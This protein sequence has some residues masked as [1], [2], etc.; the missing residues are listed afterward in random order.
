M[1]ADRYGNELSTSSAKARDS[2]VAATDALL[3]ADH[4][5]IDGF[6]AAIAEDPDFKLA[7]A[8]LARA[9]QIAA[10]GAGAKAAMAAAEAASGDLTAREAG[11]MAA[12][13]QLIDG[14]MASYP[15]LRAHLA[16]HP[17]DVLIAQPSVGVF[18]LIGFS[19]LPGREAELLAYTAS[20]APH[21]G[22]D[23]WMLAQHGF[24][25]CEAGQVEKAIPLLD[26][27][28]ELYGRNANAAHIRA[29][30]Y[31]EAGEPETGRA[32]LEDW[33]PGYDK[34]G[35][36]HSHISWHIALWAM[37]AGDLDAMW[38]RVDA[39]VGPG[40]SQGLSINILTDTVALLF[41]TMA[42]GH[43]VPAERWR[44]LSAYATEQFPN[45][46]IAFA[47]VH[48]ALAHAMAGD[49]AALA[50]IVE[51]PAGPAADVVKA[52]AEA[53]ESVAGEDWPEATRRLVRAMG[54]HARIGGSRAQR[55]LLVHML[56]YALVKQG[57]TDEARDVLG[58]HRPV[59]SD[60]PMVAGLN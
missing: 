41:R 27:S 2:Y 56:L 35:I 29:H 34:R 37:A 48:A 52:S 13:R 20:L 12:M 54:D 49:A 7:H 58:L 15:A 1:Q 26:R 50:R 3:S 55:D 18:G 45:C 53:F 6:E 43:G 17:R 25:M 44:Q 21:Y 22:D 47:D 33:V 38:A 51:A 28:L 14:P 9:R 16:E 19:G 23:W 24:S 46:G 57:R 39:D 32:F 42:A 11:H 60:A 5:A 40:G 8:G 59:Q 31:Y 36:L 30:C 10:D 4:G